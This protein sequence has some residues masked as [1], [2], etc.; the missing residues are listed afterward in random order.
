MEL[1]LV[2]VVLTGCTVDEML[3]D[4]SLATA[5][6]ADLVEV[7]LDKLWTREIELEESEEDN[8]VKT[9]KIKRFGANDEFLHNLG[10]QDYLRKEVGI[11]AN[12][13]F[14]ELNND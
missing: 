4:A 7:R 10:K 8:D 14:R 12:S 9:P 3:K 1:P 2:C 6:G 11:D 13:I 5:A